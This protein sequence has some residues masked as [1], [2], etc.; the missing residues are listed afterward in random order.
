M[1]KYYFYL[2]ASQK[3]G[4]LY[5]GMINNLRKRIFQ[6]K[7]KNIPGFTNQYRISRLVYFEEYG[8]ARD[9]I[10]REKQIKGWVRE[11]KI[12]LIESVNPEWEEI[13]L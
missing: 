10:A 13:R 1:R 7:E 9:A 12:A 5:A 11:K 3:R 8:D 4:T 6:H 2:L